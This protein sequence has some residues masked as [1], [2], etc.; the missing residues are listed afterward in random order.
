MRPLAHRALPLV[1]LRVGTVGD[2]PRLRTD[3]NAFKREQKGEPAE[4]GR[5]KEPGMVEKAGEQPEEDETTVPEGATY[6]EP[7]AHAARQPL[8]GRGSVCG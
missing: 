1:D 4:G 7:A 3:K 5:G 8:E 2:V 6:D